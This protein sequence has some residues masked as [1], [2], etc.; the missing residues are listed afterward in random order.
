MLALLALVLRRAWMRPALLRRTAASKAARAVAHD[1][2]FSTR[3]LPRRDARVARPCLAPCMDA[4]RAVAPRRGFQSCPR[5]APNVQTVLPFSTDNASLPGRPPCPT[6]SARPSPAAS[7]RAVAHAAAFSTCALPRRDARVARPF[8]PCTMRPALLRC[9][10]LRRAADSKAAPRPVACQIR[11]TVLPLLRRQRLA[12]RPAALPHVF[13]ASL[14]RGLMARRCARRCDLA[15]R[16]VASRCSCCLLLSCAVQGCGP[17]CCAAPRLP[18]LPPPRAKFANRSPDLRRQRLAARPPAL[19]HVFCVP[20]ARGLAAR[21]CARRCDLAVRRCHLALLVL[22][23]LFLR[24]ARMRP[25]VLCRA[26]ASK[27]ACA[28]CQFLNRSLDYPLATPRC[29]AGL[30]APRLLCVSRLRPHG[31]LMR[32]TL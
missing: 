16:L 4:A 26:A 12:A 30:P 31:A 23:A 14:G 21:S 3:A 9:A 22:L 20:L 24:R 27:A 7:R 11:K 19:P 10:A 18:K 8:A 29:P 2:V 15:M 6:S 1:A 17:R 28:S 25:A 32:R 5:R 13:C